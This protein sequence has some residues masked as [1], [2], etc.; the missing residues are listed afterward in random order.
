MILIIG[1]DGLLGSSLVNSFGEGEIVCTSRSPSSNQIYFD[2]SMDISSL[3]SS[4]PSVKYAVICSALSNVG[5]CQSNICEC[6]DTNYHNTVR[7]VN[8]LNSFSIPSIVFSSE[9]VFNGLSEAPYTESSPICPSTI[10]GSSKAILEAK[11]SESAQYCTIFRIS[12]LFSLNHKRSFMYKMYNEIISSSSYHAAVDQ[13]FTP[14]YLGDAI[15]VIKHC[16]R[17]DLSCNLYNLCGSDCLSRF[18][19]AHFCYL[20]SL[21]RIAKLF[22][23]LLVPPLTLS[24][25]SPESHYVIFTF[26]TSSLF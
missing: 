9:Y 3:L 20:L 13:F 1:S 15:K 7:I 18:D 5:Y 6:F 2:M 21:T 26:E 4:F 8:T 22:P 14:I 11:L 12:K 19:L 17:G 10:Y 16:I 25:I 23:P 24:M